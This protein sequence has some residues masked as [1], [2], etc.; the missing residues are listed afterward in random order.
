MILKTPIT[1]IIGFYLNTL[2]TNKLVAFI[3][4]EFKMLL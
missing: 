4:F 2:L 3:G 1:F